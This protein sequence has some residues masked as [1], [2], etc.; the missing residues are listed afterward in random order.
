MAGIDY[1][2]RY[3]RELTVHN[4]NTSVERLS[5]SELCQ[6]P[7]FVLLAEP[8]MGKTS[9]MQA[10][11]ETKGIEC[12]NASQI[13]TAA[14]YP[15]GTQ[16]L[17][18]AFD[19]A[20]GASS[21][22]MLKSINQTVHQ[23][24]L[25]LLGL[26]CR[27]VDWEKS[28]VTNLTTQ[29]SDPRVFELLPLD[30][31]Q[32]IQ[33]LSQTEF[34]YIENPE[35][36]LEQTHQK[37]FGEI[38]G[39]PQSLRMLAKAAKENGGVLPDSRNQT[40]ELACKQLLQEHNQEHVFH[41]S[42]PARWRATGWLACITLL[43]NAPYV[44]LTQSFIGEAEKNQF[45]VLSELE[46]PENQAQA[47][48]DNNVLKEI[49]HS[50]IFQKDGDT[51]AFT[52]RTIAEYMAARYLDEE[53][54]QHRILSTRLTSIML[55]HGLLI[56]NLRGLS[57]MLAALNPDIRTQLFFA[58]PASILDYGDLTLLDTPSKVTLIEAFSSHAQTDY[59]WGRWGNLEQY[60]PLAKDDMQGFVRDWLNQ[61]LIG[62]DVSISENVTADILFIAIRAQHPNEFWSDVLRNIIQSNNTEFVIRKRALYAWLVHCRVCDTR[63]QMLNWI[64]QNHSIDS[65]KELLAI[66]L[67]DMY[68]IEVTPANIL[69]YW[70][71]PSERLIG[72]FFMFWSHTLEKKTKDEHL[73]PLLDAF[74]KKT[75]SGCFIDN[76]KDYKSFKYHETPKD[77][78]RLIVKAI[79][80][81]G[82]T[83]D[84]K[85]LSLWF[86]WF[87]LSLPVSNKND[88]ISLNSWKQ[89]H[90]DLILAVISYRLRHNTPLLLWKISEGIAFPEIDMQNFGLAECSNLIADGFI[91]SSCTCLN[92]AL[93]LLNKN[94]SET[95]FVQIESLA[96]LHPKLADALSNMAFSPLEKNWQRDHYLHEKEYESFRVKQHKKELKDIGTLLADLEGVASG[97]FV[98]Y[99][100][101]AAFLDMAEYGDDFGDKKIKEW[102]EQYP[103]LRIATNKGYLHLLREQI[104]QYSA[105]NILS[106]HLDG[107]YHWLELPCRLATKNLFASDVDAFWGLGQDTLSKVLMFE[108]M[109]FRCDSAWVNA[110][111]LEQA[112]W[113]I[114]TWR[115]V[116]TNYS[117]KQEH[118]QIPYLA[119]F[120]T[121]KNLRESS[122]QVLFEVLSNWPVPAD[123]KSAT[124]YNRV[125]MTLV[126]DSSKGTELSQK[127]KE[128]L[129]SETLEKWQ[130]VSLLMAGLWVDELTFLP[131]ISRLFLDDEDYLQNGFNFF[132]TSGFYTENGQLMPKWLPK[133]VRE[134]VIL[135]APLCLPN[136]PNGGFT[137]DSKDDMRR[138]LSNIIEKQLMGSLTEEAHQILLELSNCAKL[139][140]WMEHVARYVPKHT[141]ALANNRYQTP[142]PANVAQLLNNKSP[143]NHD[144]FLAIV[145]DLL[146]QY[147]TVVNN[148]P[149]DEHQRFWDSAPNGQHKPENECR[150]VIASWLNPRLESKAINL[151]PES[152]RGDSNR[153]DIDVRFHSPNN[154]EMILPIEVKGDWHSELW[155]AAENQLYQKYSDEH[156]SNGFGVY[157]VLWSENLK[158]SR[159]RPK[160]ESIEN[161]EQLHDALKQEIRKNS[162]LDN[163]HVFVLDVSKPKKE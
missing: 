127:I 119:Q 154:S 94:H 53:L 59:Q 151:S 73:L 132:A 105:E 13:V 96:Q 23:Y 11:A 44:A 3:C 90:Q 113:F 135:F 139:G 64:H 163:I 158:R 88:L 117:L 74:D 162:M 118:I 62:R 101:H 4:A 129:L 25:T 15:K 84:I 85:T 45:T 76:G 100:H 80:R 159:S 16:L 95:L 107:K 86:S 157:L 42:E 144:D 155:T 89:S 35:Q 32:Q 111:I 108:F 148:S 68:P 99:L 131:Q 2:N 153:T 39:N 61:H 156:R 106:T 67:E 120:K 51:F 36:F 29:I 93:I 128:Q 82:E 27:I 114:Q 145:M 112:E 149:F 66:L 20:R 83:V 140:S 133:T 75:Q 43:A 47:V 31:Q 17:I 26:S 126:S 5:V 33:L 143:A 22:E 24:S 38:L 14:R 137:P 58:D 103:N 54:R 46:P 81:W 40:F 121:D 125:L 152:H 69:D 116:V 72:S 109:C 104:K 30:W 146:A 123:P 57:G 34:E 60:K 161:A 147:Q 21:I 77:F 98:S 79:E 130:R 19:E 70:S 6:V 28:N 10:L 55:S 8:G 134:I 102:L 18:D 50:R 49:L 52:H 91:D 122:L 7:T 138:I 37:G 9:V 65:D 78:Y 71:V 12:L 141:L 87:D 97:K 136:T 56:S 48:F 150:N 92:N 115:T 1:L 160:G 41:S 142:D 124:E 63:V 110:I